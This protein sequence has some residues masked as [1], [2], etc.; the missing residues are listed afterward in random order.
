MRKAIL[1]AALAAIGAGGVAA[2]EPAA[3][4][5]EFVFEEIVLL[6]QAI[7]PGET[8]RGTRRMI[9]ITGGTFEGPGISGEILP[10]G[11]DWQL[12]R[13]DGCTEIEADYFLR[14]DD[15]AVINV[16]NTG[17]LCPPVE[18]AAPTPGYTHPVFE[19]PTG[20]YEWLGRTA[21][22]GTLEMAPPEYGPA[23]KIRFFKVK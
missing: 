19:A 15:G 9:P 8:P 22:I 2:Q 10:G 20:K 3:P 7:A 5:L 18:G 4:Q 1:A 14:T 16:V 21:F 13:A 6:G 11:W 23:V 17:V 12:D